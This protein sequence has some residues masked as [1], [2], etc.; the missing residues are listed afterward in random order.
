MM[1]KFNQF[2]KDKDKD[3]DIPLIPMPIHFKHVIPDDDV[4]LIPT[5]IHFKHVS[6]EPD[7]KKRIIS[8][9]KKKLYEAVSVATNHVKNW[10]KQNDNAKISKTS[11]GVSKRLRDD[12]KTIHKDH[13]DS[14]K[15]YTEDSTSLNKHLIQNKGKP[16]KS[17]HANQSKKLDAA[18]DSN[19]SKRNHNLYSGVGF[20]PHKLAGKK[21]KIKS[22]AYISA[23]SNK[24]TAKRFAKLN[25]PD[26]IH[27]IIHF[28]IKKGDPSMH[29]AHHSLHRHE[30]ESVIKRGATLVHHGYKDYTE[31]HP[32]NGR[33]VVT[34]VHRMSVES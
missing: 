33:T 17:D 22:H 2:I 16:T 4:P 19:R 6:D 29:I 27:H 20:D 8:K 11:A 30:H 10:L 5:P 1:K 34:R 14:I 9:I 3:E 18:I 31:L 23:S 15:N 7:L 26:G 12:A 32:M 28:K 13:I 21:G 25:T 24:V